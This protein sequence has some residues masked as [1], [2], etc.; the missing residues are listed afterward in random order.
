MKK[1]VVFTVDFGDVI[2]GEEPKSKKK[3]KAKKKRKKKVK[4]PV[5]VEA[6]QPLL[7]RLVKLQG[8]RMVEPEDRWY[9]GW[10]DFCDSAFF[11][12]LSW[13]QRI[14]H[15]PSIEQITR[16]KNLARHLNY[17]KECFPEEY[18]FTPKTWIL[19]EEYQKLSEEFTTKKNKTFIVKPDASCQGKGIFLTR[20]I[21]S[22]NS[23]E[24]MVAQRYLHRPF[25]ING[26]K[27]DLRLY[28]LVTSCD[29]LRIYVLRDGLVRFCT[30]RYTQP[31]TVNLSSR[32]RHLTNYSINKGSDNFVYNQNTN[33]EDVGSKWSFEALLSYLRSEGFDDEKLWRSI[34]DLV[35][36]TLL[37]VLPVLQHNYHVWFPN[38]R[39][40]SMCYQFLG[41]DVFVDERLK[42]WLI[43]INR[44]PSLK[45]DTPLDN[46]IKEMALKHT[47]RLLRPRLIQCRRKSIRN[48]RPLTT[49]D[50]LLARLARR[51]RAE[52]Q[53]GRVIRRRADAEMEACA[54]TQYERVFPVRAEGNEG[55]LDETS[56]EFASFVEAAA[57]KFNRLSTLR[58]KSLR[59]R[60]STKKRSESRSTSSLRSSRTNSSFDPPS[61]QSNGSDDNFSDFD[62]ECF[63][64]SSGR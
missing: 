17:M 56:P 2:E 1:A 12:S 60:K 27:F 48:T 29:P 18:R 10:V 49:A 55:E 46:R 3:P 4:L 64:K 11:S 7:H 34:C 20:S 52:R 16:K 41:F 44:N 8:W 28:V 43:E 21:S 50:G 59:N 26:L 14:N 32:C 53:K 25:L 33:E 54:R 24:N 19:P 63:M 51:E 31:Q 58:P 35:V 40:G 37:A 57:Q 62:I 45:C 36:K 9:L 47:F 13:Y 30:E 23:T 39:D 42:P 22:I 38:D 6:K 5:F 61:A 15:F